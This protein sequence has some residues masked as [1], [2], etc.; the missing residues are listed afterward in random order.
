[1]FPASLPFES[2]QHMDRGDRV[3]RPRAHP[4]GARVRR[5]PK[6]ERA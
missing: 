6:G 1:M 5:R 2:L 4:S 3:R